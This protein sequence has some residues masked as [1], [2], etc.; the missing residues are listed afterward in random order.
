M[1]GNTFVALYFIIRRAFALKVEINIIS[2]G[3]SSLFKENQ[4]N[5][6]N[7]LSSRGAESLAR[8]SLS[9]DYFFRIIQL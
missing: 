5:E 1:D 2:E 8:V 3:Q 9:P 6:N 4:G 7:S